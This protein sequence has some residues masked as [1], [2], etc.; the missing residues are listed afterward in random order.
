MLR[1]GNT[2]ALTW[3]DKTMSVIRS[4]QLEACE[5]RLLRLPTT[6]L[7]SDRS[8]TLAE[9][10][11]RISND[12]QEHPQQQRLHTARE[13]QADVIIQLPAEAAL[14]TFPEEQLVE[15][16][17]SLGGEADLLD[18]DEVD[19]AESLVRRLWCTISQQDDRT[20]IHMPQELITPLMLIGGSKA[21]AEL[22]AHLMDCTAHIR[23][24]LY[25]NGMLCADQAM[26]L[27]RESVLAD[28]YANSEVL[29]M[30]YLRNA[31][32]YVYDSE[33]GMLLLHPGLADPERVLHGRKASVAGRFTMMLDE[34]QL[35]QAANG[36]MMEEM[37]LYDMMYGLL[38]DAVRPELTAEDAVEDLRMLAKQGVSLQGMNEVLSSMLIMQPTASMLDGV[39]LL[40]NLTPRWGTMHSG[41]IQ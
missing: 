2:H 30:R 31:F 27:M 5:Q 37:P 40:H 18:W 1:E 15:R 9:A 35:R 39:K 6:G 38:S 21:H 41:V 28:T 3:A 14:L 17:L 36:I 26:S 7:F 13:L 19:A 16:L 24:M 10:L 12:G 8:E 20:L 11:W 29:A 32:D 25:M 4:R 34:H 23:A 22:R 33:G